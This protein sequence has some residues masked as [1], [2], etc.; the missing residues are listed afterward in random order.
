MN[1]SMRLTADG[2]PLLSEQSLGDGKV[3]CVQ[4]A[5]HSPLGGASD[6]EFEPV[7]SAEAADELLRSIRAQADAATAAAVCKFTAE[8]EL[9]GKPKP[10][11]APIA[12]PLPAT[13]AT[14]L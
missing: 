7:S 3:L 12:S 13:S 5:R 8:R 1:V 14:M 10:A 2:K 6:W 11:S 9:T 4:L